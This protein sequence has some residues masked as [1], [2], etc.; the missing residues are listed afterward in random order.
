MSVEKKDN[1]RKPAPRKAFASELQE[2]LDILEQHHEEIGEPEQRPAAKAEPRLKRSVP[3][4]QQSPVRRA[5]AGTGTRQAKPSVRIQSKHGRKDQRYRRIGAAFQRINVVVCTLLF[6]GIGLYLVIAKRT[7]GFVDSENRN[8]AEFPSF[9]LSSYF[10]GKYADGIVD[11][12][13]DT[14]PGRERMRSSVSR[15]TSHFGFRTNDVEVYGNT[16]Q[17]EKETIS[18]EEKAVT[19]KVTVYTGTQPTTTTTTTSVSSDASGDTTAPA[20]E[21]T[22]MTTTTTAPI[23]TKAR[24]VMQDEGEILN[25]VIVSGR[26]TPNVRAMSM[27][28]G[29]F[30]TGKRYAEVLN[31]YKEMVGPTVNVYNLSAPLAS[32]YYMPKNMENQFSDQHDCI[33][34]IGLSLRDVINVDVFDT[35]QAHKD[36][37]IYFRT[38]H[39][40]TTL[41]AYYAAQKFAEEA[42]VPFADL[43]T[44]E[45]HQTDNFCGTM[46]GYT[47]YLEDLKQYP[48]TYYYYKPTNQYTI[49]YYD[50]AFRNPKDGSL[51]YDWAHGVNTYSTI[52][53]GDVN[54]AEIETDVQN[55]RTLVLIKNSYGNAMVPYFVGSF[56]KIY[57]VDFRYVKIGMQDFFQRVG[58]TD[59]LFGVAISSC[60]TKQHINA[61][62]E[63]MR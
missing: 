22:E 21:T 9:T 12:Y 6:F 8:R 31:A 2:C 34:N 56:Q 53:G 44:F 35:L 3:Q 48:D 14:I 39:H 52:L 1:S 18:E 19:S 61:I 57:V 10:S 41:G 63:I 25:N 59:V 4:T 50:D 29:K 20:S 45:Q 23:T 43:S 40:W 13:T 37:Y 36:E 11:Y 16:V 47:N 27:F 24:T 60:Y 5:A 17:G 32:A 30:E 7:S 15:F 54:I 62:E 55:G 46:Y 33:E 51:F 38:D 58:A 28:G 26:G 49:R 42:A